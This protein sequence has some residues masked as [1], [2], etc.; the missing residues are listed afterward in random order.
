M[1]VRWKEW[2]WSWNSNTLTTWC[3]ELTHLKR[4][5]CREKLKAGGEGDDRRWD[6]WMASSTRRAWVW[7]N[8]WSWW[9][10]GR[11][12]ML[13]SMELPRV[14]HDWVTKLNWT[15]G[16]PV[17]TFLRN[18]HTIFHCGYPIY[19]FPN[20][21]HV[22]FSPHPSQHLFIAFVIILFPTNVRWYLI[23]VLI[24]FPE[25]WWHW[26]F[27]LVPIGCVY[28]FFEKKK[29]LFMSSGYILIEIFDFLGILNLILCSLYV[30]NMNTLSDTS[31]VNIFFHLVGHLF[32]WQFLS[33]C[34][35]CLV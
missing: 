19:L 3:E 11:P 8:S 22:S 35:N 9:W 20:D 21:A 16:C 29:S 14:W 10:T 2:C 7:V 32:L 28:V 15:D 31:F 18:L 24:H 1:N 12:G 23:I 6:G 33:L 27:F 5:W 26:T 34:I 4:S 17:F 30:L 25:C 13:R